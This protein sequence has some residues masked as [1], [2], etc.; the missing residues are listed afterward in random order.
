MKCPNCN[1]QYEIKK[2]RYYKAR[3]VHENS[4]CPYRFDIAHHSFELVQA[5]IVEYWAEKFPWKTRERR[6]Q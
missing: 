6:T 1:Q 5:K 3:M 2:D 4:I